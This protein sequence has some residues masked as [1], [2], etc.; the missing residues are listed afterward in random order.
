VP[1][2]VLLIHGKPGK[3]YGRPPGQTPIL[4]HTPLRE[5]EDSCW[6]SRSQYGGRP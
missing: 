1:V 5:K 4:I 2:D 3:K 6:A